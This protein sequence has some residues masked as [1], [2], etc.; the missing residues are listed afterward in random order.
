VLALYPATYDEDNALW[1]RASWT[2]GREPDSMKLWYYAGDKSLWDTTAG[3]IDPLPNYFATAIAYIATARL[4][5]PLCSCANVASLAAQLRE[6]LTLSENGRGHFVGPDLLNCPFGT[7]RGE[8]MAWQRIKH[9]VRDKQLGY[10]I[11]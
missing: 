10:A 7:H 2:Q 6:D 1:E 3:A 8:Y 11:I 5:R 4:E 9:F